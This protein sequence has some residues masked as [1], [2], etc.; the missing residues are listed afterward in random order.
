VERRAFTSHGK[1]PRNPEA[2]CRSDREVLAPNVDKMLRYLE[3]RL[4]GLLFPQ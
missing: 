2:E 3:P 4:A 1:P